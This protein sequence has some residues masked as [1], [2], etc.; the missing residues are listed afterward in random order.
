MDDAINR[1]VDRMNLF[2]RE[3]ARGEMRRRITPEGRLRIR[4]V[5]EAHVSLAI[6]EWG[7]YSFELGEPMRR[8]PGPS[9][10]PIRV[11]MSY[12]SGR[13]IEREVHGQ[14]DRRNVLTLSPD[15]DRLRMAAQIGSDQLPDDVRYSLTY[16]R[17]R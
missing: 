8:V 12:R 13:L 6:D 3:I 10:D 1:V 17:A 5:D 14:G 15:G 9:G 11:A 2:I 7:P 4:V 16:R